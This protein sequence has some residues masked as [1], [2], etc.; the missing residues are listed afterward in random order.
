MGFLPS[1]A[2]L[3]PRRVI[4]PSQTSAFVSQKLPVLDTQEDECYAEDIAHDYRLEGMGSAA[5]SIGCCSGFSN[6]NDLNFL[7]TLGPKFKTLGDIC[8][9]T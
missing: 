3:R 1:Q 5:G 8:K 7:N 6:D 2:A 4:T 9:K